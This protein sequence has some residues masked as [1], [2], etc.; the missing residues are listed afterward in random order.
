LRFKS[1]WREQYKGLDIMEQLISL[2]VFCAIYYFSYMDLMS[3]IMFH[4]FTSF[5]GCPYYILIPGKYY[6]RTVINWHILYIDQ[7]NNLIISHHLDSIMFLLEY[8]FLNFFSYILA[9]IPV[10]T[11][12]PYPFIHSKKYVHVLCI[13]YERTWTYIEPQIY[14][15]PCEEN[16]YYVIVIRFFLLHA[17]RTR[18]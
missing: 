6:I 5:L 14:V 1:S 2:P 13:D 11:D 12:C 16:P 7:G 18:H 10:C 17:I 3:Y 15:A 4:V 8:H 9:N